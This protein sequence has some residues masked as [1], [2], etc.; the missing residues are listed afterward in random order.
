MFHRSSITLPRNSVVLNLGFRATRSFFWRVRNQAPFPGS[1]HLSIR[2]TLWRMFWMVPSWMLSLMVKLPEKRGVRTCGSFSFDYLSKPLE[3][4]G[5]A[6]R[7][8]LRVHSLSSHFSG[9]RLL[10]EPVHDP[11]LLLRP[12]V[13]KQE[14]PAVL[15]GVSEIQRSVQFRQASGSKNAT[16]RSPPNLTRFLTHGADAMI[17][18]LIGDNCFRAFHR[19]ARI[20][21]I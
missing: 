15:I 1:G 13:G 17:I 3:L 21:R 20:S 9:V 18:N 4:P 19:T 12:A 8:F 16:S 5:I 6:R 14:Q 11:T 10:F 2:S 7:G